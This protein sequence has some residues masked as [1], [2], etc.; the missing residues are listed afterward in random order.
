MGSGEPEAKKAKVAAA[1]DAKVVRKQVEYYLSDENLKHDKFFHEK[2]ATDKE[3]WLDLSMIVS[4]NKMKVMKATK[5][6]VV[7]ALKESKIEI[8]ADGS[9]V[10]RPGNAALPALEAK[11]S[12]AQKKS[13]LHVHDGGPV[14]VFKNIPA[15]Q[16]W[17]QIKDK[18]KTALP[19]KATV[20]FASEVND[21][22][23]CFIVCSPWDGDLDFLKDFELDLGGAKLKPEVCYNE[24]LQQTLKTLPK[25]VRD[26]RDKE[27][28]KRAKERNRPI[29]VGN[30]R[31]L[32][33]GALRGKVKEILNSRSDGEQLKKDGTDFKLIT[34]L[35]EFHPKGAEKRKG[36]VGI[37]VAK[38]KYGDSR[39]FY[40]IRENGSE[41][42][43]SMKK[44]VDAV[45]ANPP[46]V[47]IE[48][49]EEEP[50]K[51][52]KKEE[53]KEEAKTEEKKEEANVEP[54]KEEAKVEEKKEEAKTEEKKEEAKTEEK[55]EEAK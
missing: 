28:K 52:V 40:M 44:C 49:K 2:I 38:S 14:I 12:H 6:D 4:C 31:F 20:W 29:V 48:K 15:E 36:L 3:G 11:P 53:K 19:G 21:K 23:Q 30:Q 8:K 37:K 50:K 25:H 26:K 54:K 13:S 18:L 42:D 51:E 22:Q 24:A 45:E 55:K 34:S 41:E 47:K 33:V 39:C 10:R 27:S 5:E 43:V 1:P 35:L 9:A 17:Q 32:N 46:Y 7:S 16:S